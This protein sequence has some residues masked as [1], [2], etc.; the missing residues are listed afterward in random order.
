MPQS[1]A[2][3]SSRR[4]STSRSESQPHQRREKARSSQSYD[5]Y[6]S[7]HQHR[8]NA[9]GGERGG[10][11]GGGFFG[12]EAAD[13]QLQR[14]R[15]KSRTRSSPLVAVAQQHTRL[16][17]GHELWSQESSDQVHAAGKRSDESHPQTPSATNT[18]SHARRPAPHH[19]DSAAHHD[20]GAVGA[21]GT[22][23]GPFPQPSARPELLEPLPE[24]NIAIIGAQ[25]VGKSTFVQKA[26]DLPA[27][28]QTHA[29][30]CTIPIHGTFYLVRLLELP[31][32]DIDIDDDETINWPDNIENK[33]LPRVDGA[34]AL[35]DVQDKR[36]VEDLPGMLNAVTK[37]SLPTFLVSTKCDT[38]AP[39]REVDPT[40][41][42]QN[43]KRAISSI[44]TLQT[45]YLNPGSHKRGIFMLLSTIVNSHPDQRFRSSSAHRRR[46]Q[47]TAVR[48]VSPRHPSPFG[49]NRASS[50]WTAGRQKDQRHSRHDSTI[51]GHGSH[52]RLRVP[53]EHESMQTSFLLEESA[54]ASP[55]SSRSSISGDVC[56]VLPGAN[57]T[58]S[59]LTESGA[60][61]NELVDRL[62]LQPASKTDLKFAAIFLALY[63]N[64]AA[65][66][67]LLEAIV[68]RFDLL[69]RNGCPQ[70]L[71]TQTQLRYVGIVEQWVGWYPGDFA[72]PRTRR[73]LRT[74]VTKLAELRIFAQAAKEINI[75]LE[76]V[77]ED[78]D[79]NWAYC[80][81]DR[82]ASADHARSS[83][84]STAST[85]I[86]D[87]MF[88][89][90]KELSGTTLNEEAP[91]HLPKYANQMIAHVEHAQKQA[92]SL[93][94]IPRNPIT[95]I[96]WRTLYEQ[97]DELIARELTRM[98]WIMFSSIRPRDL[99]RHVSL[100]KDQRASCKNLA[101]VNRMIEH[102]NQL[103]SWVGNYVV[104]RDKP[105]H[106]ALMLEKFMR[107]AR[108]LRDLNNY[109]ALGAIIAGVKSTAVHRLVA[110]RELLP[111]AIGRDWMKLEILM[112]ASRS[113]FAY[114]LAWENSSSE[115][116]PY[117]PL[118]RRD[119]ATAEEGNKTFLDREGER[120]NWKKFEIMGDVIVGMQRAQGMPYKS[121][122]EP[123]GNE[124]IRELVLDV[125]LIKDEEDLY[126]RSVQLEPAAGTANGASAKFK[127]FFKR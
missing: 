122:G 95:K 4:C 127:E 75:D 24:I 63:R 3:E 39:E 115:R 103:A 69:E 33:M 62:L 92:Q 72:F 114:R 105:K 26:L 35:Y 101:H 8:T 51:A 25:G 13:A 45:S 36:S 1:S 112:S 43:A 83:M 74:F 59:S 17:A 89:M 88:S 108:K 20:D 70:I 73:R 15:V 18:S 50:E 123:K 38:P 77:R 28:P 5:Q 40:V 58:S 54:S 61:F 48:P 76:A 14:P 55:A 16:H 91:E 60:T 106:R 86:D 113:H 57:S 37:A 34:L 110:T 21:A 10:G 96:Q 42:E 41:V 94:A 107:I 119:L 118:H 64:F 32:E 71:K 109:N 97:P 126:D 84:S 93:Q 80:D 6:Y 19:V 79:T 100:P 116:I 2:R 125:K 87:P 30:E 65:P 9:G 102:F 111:Q 78:D 44:T 121:L 53:L 29:A 22:T 120:I 90:E 47:S 98:D 27:R 67:K 23:R 85:L 56:Q 81:R 99:V 124:T 46:A 7:Q 104:L 66:G 117:L 68:E 49:H 12:D 52:D 31:L 11:G 82:E